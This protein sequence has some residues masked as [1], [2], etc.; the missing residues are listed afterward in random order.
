V[1]GAGIAASSYYPSYGYG[2]PY[3]S[4]YGYGYGNGYYP[5]A[6]GGGYYGGGCALVQQVVWTGWGYRT[7]LVQAC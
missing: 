1:I 6:Y 7:V 5:A 3:D 4:G 2:Y